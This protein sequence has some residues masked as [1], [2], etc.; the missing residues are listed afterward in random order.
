MY[1]VCVCVCVASYWMA[2][3]IIATLEFILWNS[4]RFSWHYFIQICVFSSR[5]LSLFWS[6]F[7]KMHQTKS[8]MRAN[9]W[10]LWKLIKYFFSISTV[11][12][13]TASFR[14]FFFLHDE[15]QMWTTENIKFF[16]H[17]KKKQKF[18]INCG[19]MRYFYWFLL[20]KFRSTFYGHFK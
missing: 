17:N 3:N 12:T 2:I 15:M 13:T 18:Y 1:P 11:I 8:P 20:F 19:I 14:F 5:S 4:N 16:F 9:M 10:L 7:Q 6:T